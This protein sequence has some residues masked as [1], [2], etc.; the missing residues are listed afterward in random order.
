[1]KATERRLLTLVPRSRLGA[2]VGLAAAQAGL[3]LVQAELLSRA[4]AHLDAGPLPWL[5]AVALLRGATAYGVQA[6]GARTATSVKTGLRLALLRRGNEQITLVTRGLEALDAFFTGCL[7]QLFAAAVVPLL[8][9]ARLAVA[10][11]R[12]ALAVALTLP[13]IPVFGALVGMR[14]AELTERQWA[15][16][17]K[18]GGHFHDVIVGLPTLRAH[19]RTE[20]Q[21]SVIAELAG[22]HRKAAVRALRIAFLSSLVLELVAALS[23]ALVAVPVGL[24]L[25]DGSLLLSTGLLILLLTPEAFLPLRA[26]GTR[27]H[28]SAEGIAAADQAFAALDAPVPGHTSGSTVLPVPAHGPHVVF[29]QVSFRYPGA[30]A[31]AVRDFTLEI[32]PSER[33]ALTGP[34]G[35][36]KS[37]LLRLLLGFLTPTEGRILL[38][39][40]DLRDLDLAEWRRSVAWVPQDPH[41]FATSI[42]DNIRLGS[43]DA[44]DD[45]IHSAARAAEAHTFISA[46]PDGY[47]TALTDRGQGLSAGQRQRIALARAHLKDVPVLLLDEP[48]ARLDLA[49][50]AALLTATDSLITGRTALV[51]AHRPALLAFAD[52]VITL[53][54]TSELME[55]TR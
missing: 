35:A 14:T 13:L 52:R 33:V 31:P 30:T 43:P 37:T 25:L 9:L 54:P 38:D 16:L 15:V 24:L 5:A 53:S 49:G 50:E 44:T 8:V 48:T 29:D 12:S 3:I 27:F 42:A 47:S 2:L 39:G 46:L 23:V 45:Q 11:W 40:T 21:S 10:D 36:G 4:I 17:N 18:L 55:S 7:P 32:L 28:A 22:E 20:H 51:I 19:A 6:L 34:S 41:L 1:M 26:L